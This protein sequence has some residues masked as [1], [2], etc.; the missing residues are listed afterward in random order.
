M[1]GVDGT[2]YQENYVD[3]NYL[4][5]NYVGNIF[6]IGY[7]GEIIIINKVGCEVFPK[8]RITE[9][10]IHQERNCDTDK[11][12]HN[13]GSRGDAEHRSIISMLSRNSLIRQPA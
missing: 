10:K 7:D 12:R 9:K 8:E 6:S 13:S 2:V 5:D 1:T 3:D 11:Y 4:L